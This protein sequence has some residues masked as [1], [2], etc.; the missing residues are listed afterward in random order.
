MPT[1]RHPLR[2]YILALARA[3]ELASL[4][5]AALIADVSEMAVSKWLRSIRADLGKLRLSRIAKLRTK[6]Q[7]RLE[8]YR[9]KP[10]R[11]GRK[12]ARYEAIRRFNRSNGQ[13]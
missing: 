5:E 8:S 10:S 2:G 11:R 12:R 9:A 6:A 7:L 3:G 4:R 13:D 1:P